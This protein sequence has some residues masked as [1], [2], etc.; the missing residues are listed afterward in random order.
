M[1][2]ILKLSREQL[3]SY[4]DELLYLLATGNTLL[5]FCLLTQSEFKENKND[6]QNIQLKKYLKRIKKITTILYELKKQQN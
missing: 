6:L 3:K 4:E 5:E 1:S 2:A